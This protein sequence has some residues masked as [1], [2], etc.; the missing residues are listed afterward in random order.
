MRVTF[1]SSTRMRVAFKSSTRFSN[2]FQFI[3]KIPYCLRSNLV[4]K[5]SCGRCNNTYYGET[6]WHLS[7]RVGKHL[8]VSPVTENKSKS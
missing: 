3:D 1:K 8:G 6:C 7:V 4:Y 5:F 2:F